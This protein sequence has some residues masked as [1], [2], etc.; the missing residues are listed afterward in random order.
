MFR[1]EKKGYVLPEAEIKN[2]PGKGRGVFA[3]KSYEKDELIERA[4]TFTCEVS[5]ID[6]LYRFNDGRTIFHDY[7]FTQMGI[8]HVG[9]GWSSIYNH[10]KNNNAH[11]KVFN[12]DSTVE[13]RARKPIE[14]GEEITI[15]YTNYGSYLWFEDSENV[16]EVP[17]E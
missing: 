8:A 13:I 6:D 12:E 11:W 4:P 17:I 9:L 14:A 2:T 1:V 10:S 7:V 3:K 15:L 5:L 16:G